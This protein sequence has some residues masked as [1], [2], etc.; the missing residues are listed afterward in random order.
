MAKKIF[1]T[2]TSGFIGRNLKENLESDYSI[3]APNHHQ[4]D[5][6][7]DTAVQD[8]LKKNHCDVVIHCATYNATR[9]SKKDLSQVFYNNLRMFCN[10]AR[11][12]NLY[13]RMFFFGSG[14]EYDMRYYL[15]R[16][17]EEY[18]DTHV[19]VDDY[20]FS[21]YICARYIKNMPNMYD[22]RIFG[23]FGKYEDWEIRFISNALCKALYDTPITI[24]QNAFFDY[25]YATDLSNI[26]RRFI[27]AKTLKYHYYNV[28]TGKTIDLLSIAKKISKIAGKK[29]PV[30]LGAKE[31]KPEYS[32]DNSRLLSEFNKVQFTPLDVAIKELYT[33]Y[34]SNKTL[35]DPAL[36]LS[37][38]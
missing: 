3:F 34:L 26:M 38:K 24:R 4:L 19:P 17:S 33:W 29:I 25:L 8:Y 28:C 13:E 35:I 10:L 6:T 22:L 2:G 37:D 31:L 11:C 21:K 1:I 5:L 16:M 32:G 27:E 9:N 18:F 36:L 20:G 7:D 12:N 30:K 23:C 14:A 15:P